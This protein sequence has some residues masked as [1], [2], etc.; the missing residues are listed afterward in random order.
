ME[1]IEKLYLELDKEKRLTFSPKQKDKKTNAFYCFNENL[2]IALVLP[3]LKYGPNSD[4]DWAWKDTK[5]LY[6]LAI[7]QIITSLEVY[8]ENIFEIVTKH[9][10]ISDVNLQNLIK[11][12]ETYQ[13]QK[14]LLRTIKRNNTFND[15]QLSSIFPEFL[16]FQSGKKIKISMNLINLDPVGPFNKEWEA[17]YGHNKNS[18]SQVRHSFTHGGMGYA[19][20]K[21]IPISKIKIPEKP[22]TQLYRESYLPEIKER[23]KNAVVLASYLENQVIEKYHFEDLYPQKIR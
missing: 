13:L 21:K 20:I 2:S 12:I 16:I 1:F 22:I 19:Q 9:L 18:T 14:E 10:K 11:F 6:K 4:L 8:Y 23:I 3:T 15:L 17:T 7:C 5:A